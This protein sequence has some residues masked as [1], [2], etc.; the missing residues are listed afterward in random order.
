MQIAADRR[1]QVCSIKDSNSASRAFYAVSYSRGR[2]GNEVARGHRRNALGHPSLDGPKGGFDVLEIDPTSRTL[3]RQTQAFE[4]EHVDRPPLRRSAPDV[5]LEVVVGKVLLEGGR[6]VAAG[7]IAG[8]Y[9][10]LGK[11]AIADE[12]VDGPAASLTVNGSSALSKSSFAAPSGRSLN[13]AIQRR[14]F[15][16]VVGTRM[17]TSPVWRVSPL[18]ESAQPPTSTY[19][20]PCFSRSSTRRKTSRQPAFRARPSPTGRQRTLWPLPDERHAR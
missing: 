17:S 12:I 18:N 5:R 13:A 3:F 9:R 10:Q 7:R 16:G 6:T 2:F 8:A 11:P 4:V 14:L 1:P 15:S 20:A 19:S